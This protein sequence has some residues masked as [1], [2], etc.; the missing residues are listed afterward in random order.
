MERRKNLIQMT[1]EERQARQGILNSDVWQVHLQIKLIKIGIISLDLTVYYTYR[2]TIFKLM[3]ITI[4]GLQL[5]L[6]K[7]NSCYL[8]T[9]R[10]KQTLLN[11]INSI[12]MSATFNL[13]PIL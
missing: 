7:T 10:S 4:N 5:Q 2:E 12:E 13:G 1:I 9:E 11:E 3:K 6:Y 8:Q